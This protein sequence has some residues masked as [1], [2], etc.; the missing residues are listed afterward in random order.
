M[1]NNTGQGS[2]CK[3]ICW[4]IGIGAG[5]YLAYYLANERG[6]DQVQ[7]AV[8]GIVTMLIVG[9]VLRRIMCRGR[10]KVAVAKPASAAPSAKPAA[11]AEK[12]PQN[13]PVPRKIVVKKDAQKP[14][15][16]QGGAALDAADVSVDEPGVSEIDKKLSDLVNKAASNVA[17]DA[18]SDKLVKTT[19][20]KA[21]PLE[22]KPVEK[23]ETP[24]ATS[25]AK[26]PAKA[27]AAAKEAKAPEK[28]VAKD[29][30]APAQPK[31][32]KGEAKPAPA[33]KKAASGGEADQPIQ[34]RQPKGMD[35]PE[36]G[37]PDDLQKIDGIGVEQEQAFHKA[38]IFHF[39]QIIAM[40]R[41]DLA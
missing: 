22:L 37:T 2:F 4:L 15:P 16:A 6:Q 40:N 30:T 29:T 18:K 9:L 39:T 34:S 21:E 8:I 11:T 3:A 10:A 33:V 23:V 25:K 12:A 5:G 1:T 7:S 31:D 35:Q 26:A 41:R 20:A 13:A 32:T 19:P 38:G 27:K 14:R 24:A 36:N 28:S 17:A